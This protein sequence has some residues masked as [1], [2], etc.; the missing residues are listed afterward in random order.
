MI[1][2]KTKLEDTN[3]AVTLRIERIA[4]ERGLAEG[5]ISRAKKVAMHMLRDGL[6]QATIAAY[7]ELSQDIIEELASQT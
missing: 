4:R 2:A 1:D 5:D 7:T 3:I 6:P